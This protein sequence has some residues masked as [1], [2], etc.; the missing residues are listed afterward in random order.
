VHGIACLEPD[1]SWRIEQRVASQ[2]PQTYVVPPPVYAPYYPPTYLV[3][4]WF[5]GPPFFLG[6]IFLGGGWGH[7]HPHDG[8]RG[9]W[10]WRQLPPP[11]P[12][13]P[14]GPGGH[15]RR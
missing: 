1:G 6:G 10:D 15:F 12:P 9:A 8:W 3:D 14:P 7:V 5:Y 4:P 2:P 11:R 13:G